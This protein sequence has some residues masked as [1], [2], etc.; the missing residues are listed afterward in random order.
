MAVQFGVAHS[1]IVLGVGAIAAGPYYCAEGNFFLVTGCMS[2][3][4]NPLAVP[5]VLAFAKDWA[6]LGLID[7]VTNIARQRIWLFAGTKDTVV[8]TSVVRQLQDF[9]L[10]F[11]PKKS[12]RGVF[13]FAA[14]HAFVTDQNGISCDKP[15]ANYL[16]NCGFDSAGE[17]LKHIYGDLKPRATSLTGKLNEFDQ[18]EFALEGRPNGLAKTGFVFVPADCAALQPCR[19]HVALHGCLQDATLTGDTFTSKTGYNLWADANSI[20]V[21]Y[22]QVAA[23]EA[24]NP[25]VCWDWWGYTGLDYAQTTGAQIQAI[26]AM[27]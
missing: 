23:R 9:F 16:V 11:A 7:A 21:L 25:L 12:I 26:Y 24:V 15:D 22:P 10:E 17:I 18:S 19:V 13:D 5:E 6:S 2:G 4:V 20:I 1:A 14:A 3:P 27:L 8:D